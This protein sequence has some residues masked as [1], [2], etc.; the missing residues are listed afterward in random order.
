MSTWPDTDDR[1]VMRYLATLRLR[2][3]NSRTYYRQAL[4]SF[5][6]VARRH[7]PSSVG[8]TTIETWLREWGADRHSST[9]LHRANIVDRFL[10]H[11]VR[12][13]AISSNPVADLRAEYAVKQSRP[14][15]RALAAP[16]PDEALEA[17]HDGGSGLLCRTAP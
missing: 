4:C 12:E 16:Q 1:V 15:L 9:L 3:P 13:R 2:S 8:R 14:I 5:Q 10:D 11:L 6:D 17:L 7:R